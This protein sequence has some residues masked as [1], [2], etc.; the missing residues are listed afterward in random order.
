MFL[1]AV[2][3]YGE[4]LSADKLLTFAFIWL[5]LG[6]FHYRRPSDPAAA[7]YGCLRP[8]QLRDWVVGRRS[9]V[10]EIKCA[11]ADP[12]S[13]MANKR[14]LFIAMTKPMFTLRRR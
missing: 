2:G 3:F 7:A 12:N 4:A 5:A 8:R 9:E 6:Y 14:R 1:L 11:I 10:R 13:R